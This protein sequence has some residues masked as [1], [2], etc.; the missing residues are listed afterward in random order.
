[1]SETFYIRALH[2]SNLEGAR[3]L[4]RAVV[5]GMVAWWNG[6]GR[7]A[8]LR[9]SARSRDLVDSRAGHRVGGGWVRGRNGG[10]VGCVAGPGVCDM[11][12]GRW[13]RA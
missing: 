13:C 4:G 6:V 9:V 11:E 3:G 7:C 12:W 10:S 8:M 1:M 2:S 5:I